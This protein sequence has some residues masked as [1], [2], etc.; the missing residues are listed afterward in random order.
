MKNILKLP[1]TFYP[2]SILP[3]KLENLKSPA[4]SY[5]CRIVYERRTPSPA[6]SNINRTE[7]MYESAGLGVYCSVAFLQMCKSAGLVKSLNTVTILL[8]ILTFFSININ[9]QVKDTSKAETKEIREFWKDPK[10]TVAASRITR[11]PKIDGDPTDEIWKNVA[12]A[13]DFVQH[14]PKPY[15]RASQKTDIKIVYDDAAIYVL[16]YMYDTDIQGIRI[17]SKRRCG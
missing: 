14:R 16:A 11:A 5:I 6:D 9:A 10:P 17:W 7:S 4:D 3:Q 15:T 8:V 1:T 13:S 12:I 2:I